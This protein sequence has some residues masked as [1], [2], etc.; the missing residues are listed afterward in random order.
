MTTSTSTSITTTTTESQTTTLET[1]NIQT[2]RSKCD[3]RKNVSET[4]HW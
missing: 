1:G 2:N 4:L 3:E